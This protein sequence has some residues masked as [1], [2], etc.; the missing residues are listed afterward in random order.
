[1]KRA[2]AMKKGEKSES[3]IEKLDECEK[4]TQKITFLY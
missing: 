1:V 4:K 3:N 2:R